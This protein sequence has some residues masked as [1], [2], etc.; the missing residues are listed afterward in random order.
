MRVCLGSRVTPS[1]VSDLQTMATV[2]CTLGGAAY[3]ALLLGEEAAAG[4]HTALS[5]NRMLLRYADLLHRWGLHVQAAE[6]KHSIA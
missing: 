4:M 2:T 3:V 5:L 6:V 1:I